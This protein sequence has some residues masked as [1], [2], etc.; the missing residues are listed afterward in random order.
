MVAA[1][2]DVKGE[3][4]FGEVHGGE[5]AAKGVDELEGWASCRATMAKAVFKV[6]F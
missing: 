5:I 1:A 4:D 6:S 3:T 2:A